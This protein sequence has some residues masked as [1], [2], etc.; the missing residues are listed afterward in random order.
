MSFMHFVTR[1]LN[2]ITYHKI[3]CDL[4]IIDDAIINA[5]LDR[6]EMAAK[7]SPKRRNVFGDPI[8]PVRVYLRALND[9]RHLKGAKS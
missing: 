3:K 4:T 1:W 8:T 6:I 5:R 2:I 7:K 9:Y